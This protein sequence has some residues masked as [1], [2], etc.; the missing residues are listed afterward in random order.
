MKIGIVTIYECVSNIGSYLQAYAL[1]TA[2][3]EMGHEV[4][5]LEKEPNSIP[6]KKELFKLNPKRAFFQRIKK[7]YHYTRAIKRLTTKPTEKAD[8]LDCIIYGSDEIWNMENPYFKDPFFFGTNIKTVPKVAYAISAGIMCRETLENNAD[9]AAG[10]PS[11]RHIFVR[12]QHTK[13]L[14]EPIVQN[15]LP[16]VCDP[17]FLVPLDKLSKPLKLPK[18][19]YLV[20]Y[21]YGIPEHI[22]SVIQEFA[23]KHGLKIV[24]ASFWDMW[25]DEVYHCDP[26]QFA[27]LIKGAEYVFTTTFHGAIFA[28]RTHS[29]CCVLPI[30]EKVSDLMKRLNMTSR[31]ISENVDLD[32]FEQV[33]SQPFPAEE[34]EKTISA[35]RADSIEKL[36]EALNDIAN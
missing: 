32:E 9:I 11:F 3:R 2:L 19:K 24:S 10:I 36:T 15:D 22:Q 4:V 23:Q 1:Q 34:F 18:Y 12:D 14:I 25:Y 17:T 28:M 26:L 20:V 29:R 33:I 31:V 35:Y 27:E 16:L 7:C 21:T 8:K 5:F 30:R 13:E 6:L